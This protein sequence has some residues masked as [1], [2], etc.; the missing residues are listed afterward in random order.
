MNYLTGNLLIL[1]LLIILPQMRQQILLQ[2]LLH[3]LLA[4]IHL[5]IT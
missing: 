1:H 5:L 3:P 4:D 2:I